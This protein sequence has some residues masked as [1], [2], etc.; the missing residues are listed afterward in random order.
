MSTRLAMFKSILA[1][2]TIAIYCALPSSLTEHVYYDRWCLSDNT[3]Y[4]KIVHLLNVLTFGI[5]PL[6]ITV[7]MNCLTA[8]QLLITASRL[9]T[10]AKTCKT[11]AKVVLGLAIL[12]FVSFVPYHVLRTVIVWEIYTY[13]SDYKT[14][15]LVFTSSC[16]LA[17]N[18]CFN[19][20]SLYCT[21]LT[22]RKQFKHYLLRCVRRGNARVGIEQESDLP[23]EQT[24]GTINPVRYQRR[25]NTEIILF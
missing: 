14:A 18:S 12:F 1:V 17:L 24:S 8:R 25:S 9:Q 22:F 20:A 7:A 5:I 6:S 11:L 10:E 21:S 2:W 13:S 16:L 15:Y 19:P 3:E 4:Y 23:T